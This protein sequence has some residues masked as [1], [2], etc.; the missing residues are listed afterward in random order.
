MIETTDAFKG[1][2]GHGPAAEGIWHSAHQIYN[3][4]LE[5]SLDEQGA[6]ATRSD[7]YLPPSD[8][9][10][11][12]SIQDSQIQDSASAGGESP[13]ARKHRPCARENSSPCQSEIAPSERTKSLPS[14]TSPA[15]GSGRESPLHIGGTH[16]AAGASVSEG[17][18]REENGSKDLVA[19]AARRGLHG[20]VRAHRYVVCWQ[21]SQACVSLSRKEL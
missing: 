4:T 5:H 8:E 7:V 14:A 9:L 19:S 2:D 20:V 17:S 16:L 13:S 18:R 1:K 11:H 6:S 12:L 3:P 10:A 15:L 21:S